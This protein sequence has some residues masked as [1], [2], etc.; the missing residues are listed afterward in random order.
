[1][2]FSK[3]LCTLFRCR[4]LLI[5][6]FVS[7]SVL[8]KWESITCVDMVNSIT[9]FVIGW[10]IS[11]TRRL[12]QG[13]LLFQMARCLAGSSCPVLLFGGWGQAYLWDQGYPYDG[14]RNCQSIKWV[15]NVKD[16][17]GQKMQCHFNS[18]I[19]DS[20]MF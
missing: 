19:S 17:L 9:L 4:C 16:R 13:C 12:R 1:V 11:V 3:S 15:S 6:W 7:N 2:L 20:I 14:E 10:I 18:V 5:M 8:Q